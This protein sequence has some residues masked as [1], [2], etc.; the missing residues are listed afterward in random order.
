MFPSLL[1]GPQNFHILPHWE[2]TPPLRNLPEQKLTVGLMTPQSPVLLM[3]MMIFVGRNI[4]CQTL[5]NHPYLK[6][7]FSSWTT[8]DQPNLNIDRSKKPGQFSP[9]QKDLPKSSMSWFLYS[10]RGGC[11]CFY[12]LSQYYTFLFQTINHVHKRA[13][14]S[15]FLAH[16]AESSIHRWPIRL[17]ICPKSRPTWT[18]YES[19]ELF[20]LGDAII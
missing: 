18:I 7:I 9:A 10:V 20:T 11:I 17:Q 19:R 2:W 3:M 14:L 5:I 6:N 1:K 16:S 13:A 4:M 12:R 8:A 15:S